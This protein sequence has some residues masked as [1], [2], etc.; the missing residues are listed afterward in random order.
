MGEKSCFPSVCYFPYEPSKVSI[1]LVTRVKKLA[2]HYNDPSKLINCAYI[3]SCRC[4]IVFHFLQPHHVVHRRIVM[5]N[6]KP[7]VQFQVHC[8]WYMSFCHPSAFSSHFV[9]SYFKSWNASTGNSFYNH[10]NGTNWFYS[11]TS[12]TENNHNSHFIIII[13]IW[14]YFISFYFTLSPDR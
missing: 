3:C 9:I 7:T 13:I 1:R 5:G 10:S 4:V 12:E 8:M 6:G 14:F 2:E 11:Y